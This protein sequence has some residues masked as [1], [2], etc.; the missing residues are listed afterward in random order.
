MPLPI[1]RAR[2]WWVVVQV[3][4]HGSRRRLGG[5]RAQHHV[6]QHHVRSPPPPPPP[7]PPPAPTHPPHY[8]PPPQQ[9]LDFLLVHGLDHVLVV[10]GDE[11]H[12][13][14]GWGWWGVWW[15]GV[16][17]WVVVVGWG[18][19]VCGGGGGRGCASRRVGGQSSE[20][21]LPAPS[22]R[23][24]AIHRGPP[25]V[26]RRLHPRS[27][28]AHACLPH[29]PLL[30]GEGISRSAWSPQMDRMYWEGST[31]SAVRS[32][33][34]RAERQGAAGGGGGQAQRFYIACSNMQPSWAAL[35]PGPALYKSTHTPCAPCAPRAHWKAVGQ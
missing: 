33:Q 22:P 25:S 11:E 21:L 24:C 28:A 7:P 19:V 34:Q 30:P 29:L 23:P 5:V 1:E 10:V 27:A 16:V 13:G 32:R 17:G 6:M 3:D 15:V 35:L 31:P 20:R 12:A 4:R 26:N 18:G 8:H 14:G 2:D 9:Q